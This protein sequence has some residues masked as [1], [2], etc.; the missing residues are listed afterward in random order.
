MRKKVLGFT[1]IELM[2]VVAIIAIIA[3]IAIPGLIRARI[4]ANEGSAIGS[5]R[6]M[7]TSQAQFQSGANVDQDE[8]GTGEYGLLNELCGY[9]TIRTS[10][11]NT[12]AK[13][14]PGFISVSFKAT[15]ADPTTATIGV[16]NKS[17]YIYKMILPGTAAVSD[18]VGNVPAGV[19]GNADVQEA[20]WVCYAFP[21]K[22]RSSGVRAFCV[23]AAA[24]VVATSNINGS[25]GVYGNTSPTYDSAMDN[26]GV[27]LATDNFARLMTSGKAHVGLVWASV[28]S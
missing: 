18:L 16:S 12:G 5:L 21:I 2:I 9:S 3:A 26:T 11:A 15:N 25:A 14:N 27:T 28:G 4:S 24:E 7:G 8:N 6:S 13:I 19:A 10:T 23:D 1:L 22:W 20:S 17:G